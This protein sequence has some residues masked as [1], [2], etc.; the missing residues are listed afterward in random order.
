MTSPMDF[1][2]EAS[3]LRHSQTIS[4]LLLVTAVATLFLTLQGTALVSA[5]VTA[6]GRYALASGSKLSQVGLEVG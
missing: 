6:L 4:R 3:G 1:R 2:R 5:V